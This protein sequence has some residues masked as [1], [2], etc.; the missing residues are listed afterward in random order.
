MNSWDRIRSYLQQNVSAESYDNWLK[1]AVYV[2]TEETTLF[3]SVPDRETCM[4]L[5]K[6]YAALVRTAIQ[7]FGLPIEHVCYEVQPIR[8]AKNQAMAA[9][10]GGELDS[11]LTLNPKFTFDT[12]VVGACN[13]FAHAAARSVATNPSRSYNPLFLYG[14]VGMGK[15]HLM[16]AIGRELMDKFGSMRVI[17]TSSERFMNEMIACIR[18]D[19]MPQFHQRYR[20]ADV[21]LV[22][23]IQLLGNKER[24]QEEFF[25]TFNELHDHQK[26]IVISSDATPK[27][28]P[29]LL[30]RLRSR[31]EWGLM[32]D[33]QPPDLETKMAILDKK[34]EAEGVKLPDDVRSFMA[35]KTKS[36][37][38]E[39]EG[40]LIKLIA[41]SS[42][43]G[44]PIHLQMA[45]QV[46]KHLVH[47][48]DR[49]VTIDSIQ[50]AVAE[51]FQIKQSQLKEKSNTKKVVYPRQVAMYLVKELTDA[52]LPEIGRAFGGKH[53]TT[54]IHSV[55]KIEQTR[56]IDPE[57]NRLLHSL[58]DS[59]Q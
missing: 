58:M 57:L 44:T 45:Q 3:V 48:Q 7:E 27:D 54:V 39:L 56:H 30:E 1:G 26:Q 36:N 11:A 12:F 49:K 37:V 29:G 59:L 43:T 2:R 32:A 13:Q 35:A 31:F 21:L 41:Y 24:T 33:I 14:G 19:R 50:K 53:H 38:R 6:E 46:L 16:H 9:V 5:E 15:T 47:V 40:T 23:D 8:G 28:I 4:W 55:N 20:E 51:R 22:D 10:E 18:T 25:H 42:L 17:Y 52:S 34:A